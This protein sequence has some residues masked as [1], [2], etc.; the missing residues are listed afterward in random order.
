MSRTVSKDLLAFIPE[1]IP[2]WLKEQPRWAP[3][4]AVWKESKGKYDKIPHNPRNPQFRLST[5]KPESWG[6]LHKTLAVIGEHKGKFAGPGYVMTAPHGLVGVDLDRCIDDLG[7]VEDWALVVCRKLGSYCEVSPSGNGL[8]IFGLG[9]VPND[10]TNHEVGIEV[11]GGNEARFLTVTGQRMPFASESVQ[12][13]DPAVL[14]ALASEYAREKRKA[15]VI[16]LTVP[17]LIAVGELPDVSALGLP[18]RVAA[19]LATGETGADRSETLF[20]TG[21]SLCAKGLDDAQV[22]SIL[23]TNEFAFGVA[24]AKRNDDYDRAMFY[25]W[26]EHCVKA[27][28]RAASSIATVDDFDVIEAEPGEPERLKLT[29]T[30]SGAIEATVDNVT[31][32]IMSSAFSG[33]EIRQDTFKDDI[34]IRPAGN[35]RG[36]KPLED[37]DYTELRIALE[38]KQFKAIGRELIRDVVALVAARNQFD[39]AI[40][41]LSELKWDGVE[42]VPKFLARYFNAEDSDYTRAVSNYMWSAMAG[43]VLEPGIK[44]D[45]VPV[46]IG[47]QGSGKSSS[48]A[49]M[50]PSVD[51][52]CEI[53]FH[54]KEEDLAR[55]MRGRLIAE[56]GELKGLNTR[57]QEHIKAFVTRTHENWIPKYKER[58]TVFARRLLFIGTTNQDQFLAD[59]TGNRRWLPVQ[60][61]T[62]DVEGIKRD[63][64]QLWAEARIMFEFMGVEFREAENLAKDKHAQHTISEVWVEDIE[65][66]L[67][68]PDALTDETP[69]MREFLRVGE[70]ARGAL[71][72]DGKQLGRREEMRINKAMKDCGY[73][74]EVRRIGGK[75]TRV[76]VKALQPVTS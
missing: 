6:D 66:W 69:R 23:A 74:R 39:S 37:N 19:F 15:E 31:T 40:E 47:E 2:T 51:M 46:L 41:W 9:S 33:V 59:E 55:K 28:T 11:Y 10:W 50:S 60:T 53:S 62:A 72:M 1:N 57:D 61:L 63:R 27:R 30:N 35:V 16:D 22:L 67:G 65:R 25:L 48:V 29:R 76:L 70:I 3:W 17:E 56:I 43:R 52:F 54:E 42:R 12:P 58:Q 34:M 26:R 68:T 45:M 8:R 36:W 64:L 7:I 18:E 4:E 5:A 24:L 75:P 21:L 20:F 13:F 38:R 14:E 49:A 44:A 32:A 73:I 71:H